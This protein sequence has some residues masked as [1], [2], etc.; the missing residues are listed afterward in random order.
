MFE[1][2]V[3]DCVAALPSK[4]DGEVY[5]PAFV[6]AVNRLVFAGSN[7][8]VESYSVAYRPTLPEGLPS[9]ILAGSV[10]T[11]NAALCAETRDLRD[12]LATRAEG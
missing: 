7:R 3:G 2:L 6:D 4:L 9:I 10:E 11:E 8:I 12:W 1:A 5:K